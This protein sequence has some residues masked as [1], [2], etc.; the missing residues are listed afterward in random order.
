MGGKVAQ[1]LASRRPAG[2]E[3]LVLVAPSPPTPLGLPLEVRQGMVEAYATR[4]SIVATVEQVLAGRALDADDL[5]TVISDSLRGSCA[6]KAAWPLT[7][8]Q[9]DI[10]NAVAS[11][12]V[13]TLVIS[14]ELDR[15]DPPTVLQQELVA[16]IPQAE[17]HLLPGVG[18]LSPLEAPG[19]LAA[20]LKA[21]V[22][23]TGTS[24]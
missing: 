9:E 20:R 13:P 24:G 21:F 22:R 10:G 11:I 14:G 12:A 8:S 16:R 23:S 2:L 18:H 6:A 19:E 1:L 15:V 4:E 17:L 5:E 3:G 7:A